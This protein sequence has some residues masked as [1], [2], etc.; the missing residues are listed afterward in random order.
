[1]GRSVLHPSAGATMYV[2]ERGKSVD[3]ESR[4]S[5]MAVWK[6][7]MYE[8]S[9]RAMVAAWKTVSWKRHTMRSGHHTSRRT[10]DC[11]MFVACLMLVVNGSKVDAM[12]NG[13]SARPCRK[14]QV[15]SGQ[16]FSACGCLWFV[17][18]IN[19]LTHTHSLTQP[20]IHDSSQE[21]HSTKQD[22]WNGSTPT[23]ARVHAIHHHSSSSRLEQG[24]PASQPQRA[25]AGRM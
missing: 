11:S 25:T 5:V 20:V 8:A 17:S 24:K 4:C 21:S 6:R 10:T 18:P 23:A 12:C 19:A 16:P 22:L 15:S 7:L 13:R 2:N 9:T 1:G 3:H 14:C